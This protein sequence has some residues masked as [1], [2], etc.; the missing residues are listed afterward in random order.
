ML[1]LQSA[2]I[3]FALQAVQQASDL[4]KQVQAEMASSA[5]TK[6]DRSPVTVADFAAQALVAFRL[7]QALPGDT[8]VA[9]EASQALS[10][11]A[12]AAT[13]QRVSEYVRRFIPD[14]I[15]E[16]VCD[17]IDRG[18][19]QPRGRYWVL[20]PIDGTKGFLRRGQYAVALALVEETQVQLGV[21]GCPNLVGSCR[22]E[23]GGA[24]SLAV[25]QRGRGAWTVPLENEGSDALLD[26]QR[27]ARLQASP[28]QDP[29]QIRLLRSFE[30]AHTNTAIIDRLMER[31]GVQAQAMRLDS[32]AKYA[33]L[34][35][36]SGEVLVR[37]PPQGN[38][39]YKE[40][41][42]DQ[43]AG[44]LVIEE[45]GGRITDLHGKALDFS[46]GRTLANNR[47]V[48]ATNG[49]LHERIVELLA[50]LTA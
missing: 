28:C 30:S 4:V 33:L 25:A 45:A 32:Q 21:L 41:I 47:G 24:G 10:T 18:A 40:K 6:D 19:G 35:A 27:F 49:P 31:L 23:F 39:G 20:D 26:C 1:D 11:S 38:P 13:L 43:A 46:A 44:S 37:L 7:D 5:M 22:Q 3:Q 36:G 29:S 48:L 12:G 50:D 14:A 34:A 15:P 42:W 9:E 16:R 17:W 8:L 2:E